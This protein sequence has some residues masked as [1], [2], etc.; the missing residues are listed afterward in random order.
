MMDALLKGEAI[1]GVQPFSLKVLT[2]QDLPGDIQAVFL[3]VVQV[4]KD[5]VYDQ[6]VVSGFQP[7]DA[8]YR[9]IPEADR[10]AKP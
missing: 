6:I 9:D 7:Y 8:V 5:N 4:T 3:P 2:G 10:P 1:T